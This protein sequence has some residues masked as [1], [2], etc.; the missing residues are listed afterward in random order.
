MIKKNIYESLKA[1]YGHVASWA[2]WKRPNGSLKSNVG[3]VSM[4]DNDNILEVLNDRYVFVGLNGSGVHDDFMDMD[5]PWHNFHSSSPRGNDYKL[6]YALL[7]TPY[8]GA[9]ITDAI[10]EFPEVN[11]GKVKDY[12]KRHPDVVKKNM[13]VLKNEIE[14]LGEKPVVVCL[15]GASYK[16]V[17]EHLGNTFTV[18]MIKHYSFTIGKEDYREHVLGVLSNGAEKFNI[19]KVSTPNKAVDDPDGNVNTVKPVLIKNSVSHDGIPSLDEQLKKLELDIPNKWRGDIRDRLLLLFEPVVKD[20]EF[21]I[22]IN[23]RDTSKSGLDLIYKGEKRRYMGF[24]KKGNMNIKFFPIKKFYDEI[25]YKV[26]LPE[27][28]PKKRQ[29]HMEMSLVEFWEFLYIITR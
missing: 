9:Y 15:G 13:E 8:W 26:E 28:D 21:T 1:K 20:T 2:V 12:L 27:C 29:P 18:K 23:E 7:D 4:F 14:M 16:L 5:R 11:S 10:K 6:R 24:E 19:P 3:D 17:S 25:K 22:Q